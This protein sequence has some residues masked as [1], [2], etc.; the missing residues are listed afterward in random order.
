MVAT[1]YSSSRSSYVTSVTVVEKRT[2]LN[3]CAAQRQ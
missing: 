3:W 2:L 1:A